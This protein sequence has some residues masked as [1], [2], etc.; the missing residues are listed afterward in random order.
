MRKK[1]IK[2]RCI[3]PL[4]KAFKRLQLDVKIQLKE[5]ERRESL[6]IAT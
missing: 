3:E 4:E 1:T 5:K 2:I 6:E